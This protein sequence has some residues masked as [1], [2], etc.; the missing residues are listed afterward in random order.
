MTDDV[1]RWVITAGVLLAALSMLVQAIVLIR[2]GGVVRKLKKDADPAIEQATKVADRVEKTLEKAAPLIE[3]VGPVVEKAGPVLETVHTMLQ[4]AEPAIHK[5]GPAIDKIGAMAEKT[6]NLIGNVNRMVDETRPKIEEIS[7]EAVA[8][9]K[10]SRDQVEKVGE[11]LQDAAGRARTRLDQI[12]QSIT[13]TVA[14]VEEA[15]E[16]I[17]HIVMRPVREVNGVAAGVSAALSALVRK[18]APVDEAT[19]DEEMFI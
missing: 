8:V 14:Q 6:G 15:S 18:K 19:Q 16:S 5:A 3:K 2:I 1:F 10:S 12:D 11:L 7:N 17:K 4:K 9:V 13:S